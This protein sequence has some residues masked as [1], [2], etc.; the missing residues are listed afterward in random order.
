MVSNHKCLSF[1]SNLNIIFIE[2]IFIIN[3]IVSLSTDNE[4]MLLLW[5]I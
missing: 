3:L 4:K 5:F 1:L 2:M